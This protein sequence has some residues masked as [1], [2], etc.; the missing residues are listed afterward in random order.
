MTHMSLSGLQT[1][2]RPGGRRPAVLLTLLLALA[3]P[4]G[5]AAAEAGLPQPAAN[6]AVD[7]QWGGHLKLRGSVAWPRSDSVYGEVDTAPWLDG[8]GEIR[9]KNKLFFGQTAYCD[10]H[11]GAVV[12]GGDTRRRSE[13][14]GL[15]GPARFF[16]APRQLED[17]RRLLDLTTTIT[18]DDSTLVFH[19]LDRLSLTLTPSWVLV[20]IGRQAVTWGNGLVFNP[21]DLFNPF[22]PVDIERDYKVGDDMALAQVELGACANGQLL[23]VPR[24]HP[25]SRELRWDQSSIAAKYHFAGGGAEWDLM[26]ARHY[27]DHVAGVGGSSYLGDAAWRA[28][29]TWT[30]LEDGGGFFA[31]VANMDYSWA[32]MGKNWYGLAEFFYSGLGDPDPLDALA[33]DDLRVRLERGELFTLGRFYLAGSLQVELHPLLNLFLTAI[34]N[35]EDPSGILQ[36][37][38]AWDAA[39]NLQV[40]AGVN[41][42]W[43]VAGTEYGGALPPAT[44]T[45][46]RSP[47]SAYLWISYYF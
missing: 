39:Q 45:C 33:D 15:L 21:M 44:D 2:R 13:A 19:R 42:F 40:T 41:L 32:A 37:R 5:L 8:N 47:E 46:L 1:P 18:E 4:A 43:G 27:R 28:D 24:R 12:S 31:F 34:T 9:L 26:A 3:L 22:A 30:L 20:R 6:P 16:A 36:P 35:L 38:V 29:G 17:D 25:D 23:C 10:T 7:L 14:L 11:Y